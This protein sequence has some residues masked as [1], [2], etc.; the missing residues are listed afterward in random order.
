[1]LILGIDT[2]NYTT[3][4]ALFDSEKRT[5]AQRK[6]LLPVKAGEKGL[7]QS[8]AVFHHTVQLPQLMEELFDGAGDIAAVGVSEKPRDAEGSYMPCFLVGVNSARC[9]GAAAGKPVHAFSHQAGHIMAALWS[10]GA[11]ELIDR[12][13]IAFHVSGGTTEMLL[14]SPDEQRGFAVRLIA[15]DTGPTRPMNMTSIYRIFAPRFS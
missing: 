11:L 13:F 15:S 7:R 8:D 9:V 12:E 3:S 5:V 4:C 2:S 10:A 1:M 14:V 6:R